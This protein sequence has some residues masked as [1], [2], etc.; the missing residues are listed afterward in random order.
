[1][2]IVRVA[3]LQ[4]FIRPV[5][6]F[7]DF[8]AQV[9]GLVETAGDYGAELL[10]FPEYFS[11]QLLTL[12]D[13]RRPM[14]EQVRELARQSPRILELMSQLAQAHELYIVAGTVLV[15]NP[16]TGNLNNVSHLLAP[17]G[18]IGRQPK[19]HLTRFERE[20]WD[21][22]AVRE[23][24]TFETHF[25]RLGIAICYDVEF[26]EI[27]RELG[28]NGAQILVVPSCTDDRQGFLRVR[29]CAHARAIENQMYV[30]Q[31]STVGSLP[32]VPAVSLN[33]GQA[34]ILTPSDFAFSRDGIAA[35]GIPNQETMVI[36]DINLD[37]L[38]E[39]RS[40][41]T[42][43]P[44]VDA[45]RHRATPLVA[46][47]QRL[48]PPGQQDFVVRATRPSDF[49]A[50]VGLIERLGPSAP[51]WTEQQLAAQLE[52]FPEGQLVAVDTGDNRV[53]GM[54]AS[55]VVPWNGYT[56]TGRYQDWT[57][58]GTFARHDDAGRTLYGLEVLVDPSLRGHG[59]GRLLYRARQG[60]AVRHRLLRIRMGVRLRGY[61]AYRQA[62]TAEEYTAK[63]CRGELQDP[64]LPRLL[65]QGFRVLEVVTGHQPDDPE[66][67]GHAAMLEWLNPAVATAQ[68]YAQLPERYRPPQQPQP[69]PSAPRG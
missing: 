60:L 17:D 51:A 52:A 41:G 7:E 49:P 64:T 19:I 55:L 29:L 11:L 33:Y 45:E 4:Y 1:M 38:A 67:L 3:S 34:S 15:E 50:L 14:T 2:D 39:S 40:S 22:E 28:R 53:V 62:M 26:P 23:L 13:L 37:E 54:A 59:I 69:P 21:V 65:R 35:E 25:G 46:A 31:A 16:K 8:A 12:G 18:A 9:T 44:L 58:G 42:V 47:L 57:D 36:A 5:K 32:A 20:D 61:A 24:H 56:P 68:D 48:G 43:L 63:V 6:S 30:V 27:A 66:S 10:V